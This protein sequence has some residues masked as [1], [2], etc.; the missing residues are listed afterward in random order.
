MSGYYQGNRG[1]GAPGVA[2]GYGRGAGRGYPHP[3]GAMGM[4]GYQQQGPPPQM[5]DPRD[6]MMRG[7]KHL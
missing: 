3:P 5:P 1:G 4:M 7:Y 6:P 2:G